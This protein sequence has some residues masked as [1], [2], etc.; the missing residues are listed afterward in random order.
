MARPTV[1]NEPL[2]EYLTPFLATMAFP[3][4]FPDGKGDATN[5]SLYQDVPLGEKNQ[6]SFEIWRK[7]DGGWFYR[8]ASHHRFAYLALNMMERKRMLQQKGILLKQNP[9]EAHLT[10]E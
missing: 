10:T 7:K 6:T 1:N 2:N 9:G 3:T 5:T 4:I 8:F